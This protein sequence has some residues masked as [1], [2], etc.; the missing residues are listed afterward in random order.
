MPTITLPHKFEPRPYQLPF[1]RAMDGGLKRAVLV[2][3]RRAGKDKACLNFLTKKML[4]RVGAYF[5]ILPTYTQAKKIIWE[6]ID[7]DGFKF[8]DHIPKEIRKRV[9]N[10]EMVIELKNGSIFRLI[11][12]DK[13]DSIVGTNPVGIVFSEYSLQDPS[14]WQM[15]RPILAENGGWAVFNFTPRGKNHAYGIF[16]I[17]S[18]SEHWFCDRLTI[19][20][21]NVL[22]VAD[23]DREREEG[24]S[25]ELIDQEYFC[26]SPY[27]Y[28]LTADLKWK[29][30]EDVK[31]GDDLI[32]IDE[33][34]KIATERKLRH[35]K[36]LKRWETKKECRK[37]TFADGTSIIAS[38]EHPFLEKAKPI[39]GKRKTYAWVETRDLKEGMTIADTGLRPWLT[40]HT[41]EDGYMAGLFDG[42][43][44]ISRTS[45]QVAQVE[46][47]VLNSV[48]NYFNKR[49]IKFFE[50]VNKGCVSIHFSFKES[51]KVLGSVRPQRLLEKTSIWDGRFPFNSQKPLKIT[52]IEEVGLQRVIG[53]STS[54]KT[55]IAEGLVTHN[56]SFEGSIEGSYYGK[57]MRKLEEDNHIRES[58]YDPT[59][60]V[61]TDWDLGMNDSNAILF[62]QTI[63]NEIRFIDYYETSGESL[64][65][66]AKFLKDKPY[67]YGRHYFPHDAEVRELGTG[68]SRKEIAESLG[69]RPLEVVKRVEAKEDGIEA[70][71]G[72]LPRVYID[73][74][75]CERLID[76][77]NSYSKKWD[78]K[79]KVYKNTP[80]H[81]WSS[82]GADAVQTFALRHRENVTNYVRPN[83]TYNSNG[84]PISVG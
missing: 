30:M 55:F 2:H 42:E 83:I 34:C 41:R 47:K 44:C 81:D 76:C 49:K 51:L 19:K 62:S 54:T 21:T 20:D 36:V 33:D 52:S 78:E 16:K 72:I 22:S 12:S 5:Y 66:Y 27:T 75:K 26:L 1:F 79:N 29:T 28:V 69:I 57:I 11:G 59:Y 56:C 82:H 65:Y 10:T 3:H 7:K 74:T 43:G 35:S 48:R 80:N 45:V 15:L 64:Q 84:V 67:S 4:E 73:A 31:E 40:G 18:K 61:D 37:I 38:L 8:L 50:T 32:G 63:A 25:Q 58:L 68:K 39:K 71:R 9:D 17:A 70:V 6:G 60:P 13:I 23:M 46:G 14:A 24:M 53:I 77:L